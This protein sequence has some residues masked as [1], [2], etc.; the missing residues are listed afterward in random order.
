MT[1]RASSR[2][3]NL[4]RALA[5]EAARLMAQHGIHDFLAAKRKA[6]ERLGVTDSATLPRNVEIEAALIEYQRLFDASG[7]DESLAAQRRAA[8]SAMRLLHDFKPRL[9]G[10]VLSGTAT[11]HA[12]VQ[13]HLFAERPENVILRLLD[14]GIAHEAI[15]RRHRVDAG[16]VRPYPGL[17][18]EFSGQE[19]E[20]TVFPLDGIRQAPVSPVDGRPMRRADAAEVETLLAKGGEVMRSTERPGAGG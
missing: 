6:A 5:Q 1:R 16:R 11:A 14:R 17:R 7:H 3:A 4:R 15:E 8:A 18:F 9:V 12:P 2:H 20:V 10:P 13:L 19:F